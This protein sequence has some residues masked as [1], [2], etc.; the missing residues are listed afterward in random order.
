MDFKMHMA[1]MMI[2]K[3]IME[4]ETNVL[5]DL[6][7]LWSG[8]VSVL[9]WDGGNRNSIFALL[10]LCDDDRNALVVKAFVTAF[11]IFPRT[12]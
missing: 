4:K 10:M 3:A 2:V 5:I 1:G 8:N 6:L 11:A 12:S 9:N 7:K